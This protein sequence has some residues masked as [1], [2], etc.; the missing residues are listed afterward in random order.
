MLEKVKL[1]LL[2]IYENKR[3]FISCVLLLLIIASTF[4]LIYIKYSPGNTTNAYDDNAV[5]VF[6]EE[7]QDGG[8]K[9]VVSI[10][11][12]VNAP[13]LVS[14][15][16]GGRVYEA[17]ALAGGALDAAD[18]D[19]INLAREMKDGE[20]VFIPEGESEIEVA[21][22]RAEDGSVT[23]KININTA[24]AERLCDLPQVGPAIAQRIIDYRESANGFKNID[25]I[26]NVKGIGNAVFEELKDLIEV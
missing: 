21:P 1:F 6:N 7:Y 25:E 10:Q 26:K 19:K 16:K 17:V 22:P 11:G 23:A 3:L 15:K 5:T 18:F 13:G 2:N 24:S 14:L 12:A 20:E 8:G 9:I 4:T